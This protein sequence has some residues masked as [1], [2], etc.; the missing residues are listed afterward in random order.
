MNTLEMEIALSLHFNY[1]QNLI[2]PNVSWGMYLM[3]RPLHECDLLIC[4]GSGYLWEVE[5]KVSKSD[6]L[7]DKKKKHGHFH[8]ALK[9][10]YF[11]IPEKLSPYIGEIQDNAGVIVVS[12]RSR[13]C[14]EVVRPAKNKKGLA[15]NMKQRLKLAELGAMR[16]WGV[17]QKLIKKGRK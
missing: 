15:L 6:L 13:I 3:G 7:A 8:P 12:K 10:L 5:I 1:R 16:I 17:K 9:R 14:C 11:A 2:V 4:T